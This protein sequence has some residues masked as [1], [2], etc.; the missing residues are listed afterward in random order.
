M[1]HVTLFALVLAAGCTEPVPPT[2][3][4]AGIASDLD[5]G[6]PI[7]AEVLPDAATDAGLRP[8]PMRDAG[9][10]EPDDRCPLTGATTFVSAGRLPAPTGRARAIVIGDALHVFAGSLGRELSDE[11]WLARI[12]ADGT[13]GDFVREQP[14]PIPVDWSGTPVVADG[15][16]FLTGG[17]LGVGRSS[18]MVYEAIVRPDG[19]IEAWEA[20]TSLPEPDV[21]ANHAALPWG[22]GMIL[23]GGET[24]GKGL[25]SG[26]WITGWFTETGEIGWDTPVAQWDEWYVDLLFGAAIVDGYLFA[27]SLQIMERADAATLEDWV[28]LDGV[29]ALPI[30]GRG[31]WLLA[32]TENELVRAEVGTDGSPGPW[33]TLATCPVEM[34]YGG[35]VI[36]TSDTHAYIVGGGPF[37]RESDE[38]WMASLCAP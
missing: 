17:R 30:D 19:V 18:G 38:V 11:V 2:D 27:G 1:R 29:P 15:R 31:S 25:G 20:R 36:V 21:R 14:L 22:D 37:S 6:E 26:S 7:D 4:D 32:S 23:L 28:E 34:T 33:E 35:P 3:D 13:V 10:P 12:R 9:P 5:A 8:R 24:W 16:L